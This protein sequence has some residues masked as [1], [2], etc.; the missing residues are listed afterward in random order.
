MKV[1][2]DPKFILHSYVRT[3]TIEI[4]MIAFVLKSPLQEQVQNYSV[5]T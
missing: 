1:H 3:S 5:G 2:E 4:N